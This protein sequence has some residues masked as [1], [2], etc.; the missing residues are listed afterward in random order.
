MREEKVYSASD[1][2][3]INERASP[4]M[5]GTDVDDT[6]IFLDIK[7]HQFVY[8]KPCIKHYNRA[9]CSVHQAS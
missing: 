9:H 6:K 7:Y 3:L 5:S 2:A 4:C 8:I 1:L